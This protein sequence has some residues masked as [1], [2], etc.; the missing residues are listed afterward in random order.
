MGYQRDTLLLLSQGLEI[1][2]LEPGDDDDEDDS[3]SDEGSE[4]DEGFADEGGEGLEGPAG[5]GGPGQARRRRGP[6]R[7]VQE[8][9]CRVS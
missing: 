3:E 9:T 8:V 2:G 5:E 1:V 6:R 7:Q 4:G